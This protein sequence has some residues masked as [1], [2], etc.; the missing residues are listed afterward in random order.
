MPHVSQIQIWVVKDNDI[1]APDPSCPYWVAFT[2]LIKYSHVLV[3][4]KLPMASILFLVI[5]LLVFN[6]GNK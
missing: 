4:S 5:S 3:A 6:T 1:L 2:Q